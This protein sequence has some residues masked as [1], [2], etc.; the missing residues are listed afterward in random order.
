MEE[1]PFKLPDIYIVI[2]SGAVQTI[3]GLD[4]NVNVSLIDLDNY[5]DSQDAKELEAIAKIRGL[6]YHNV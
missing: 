2:K 3:R 5:P 6:T 1:G 4:E